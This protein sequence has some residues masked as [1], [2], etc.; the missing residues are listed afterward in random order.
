MFHSLFVRFHSLGHMDCERSP[1]PTIDYDCFSICCG[2]RPVPMRLPLA[3][4]N[5]PGKRD[6][7][8]KVFSAPLDPRTEPQ[9][10][11]SGWETLIR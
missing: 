2:A 7:A 10:L 5:A 1:N 11:V 3:N 4:R 8:V 9:G 6:I